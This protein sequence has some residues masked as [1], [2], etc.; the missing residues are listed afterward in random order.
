MREWPHL[1]VLPSWLGMLGLNS[2]FTARDEVVVEFEKVSQAA[3]PSAF[4]ERGSDA[5][6]YH[7]VPA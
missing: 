1:E 7:Q 3:S 4:L 5:G 2:V 6:L